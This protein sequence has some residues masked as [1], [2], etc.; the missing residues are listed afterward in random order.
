MLCTPNCASPIYNHLRL[1]NAFDPFLHCLLR[2]I[3]TRLIYERIVWLPCSYVTQQLHHADHRIVVV[4]DVLV[5]SRWVRIELRPTTI[6]ILRLQEVI[7]PLQER[8][9]MPFLMLSC[10]DAREKRQ[11]RVRGAVVDRGISLLPIAEKCCFVR[12]VEWLGHVDVLGPAAGVALIKKDDIGDAQR[13]NT[14]IPF[15]RLIRRV[16]PR[17]RADRLISFAGQHTD[18]TT[19]KT[20]ARKLRCFSIS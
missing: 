6:R 17:D 3:T 9:T 12:V 19:E 20:L 15:D 5:V 10:I 7:E 13:F 4:R 11:L 8:L 16:D 2:T 14:R 18:S 1:Q